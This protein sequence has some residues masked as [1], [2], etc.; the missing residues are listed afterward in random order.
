MGLMI[1][2]ATMAALG[3]VG[4]DSAPDRMPDPP[5]V[6]EPEPEQPASEAPPTAA[7]N[8]PAEPPIEEPGPVDEPEPERPPLRAP[9]QH[10][11]V[12]APCDDARP[13]SEW[14][15][16]DEEDG[17]TA[18]ADCQEGVNGR[19]RRFRFGW[20]CTY[21]RCGASADCDNV[22]LC[23]GRGASGGSELFNADGNVCVGGN[24]RS[25]ADC[26]PDGYCSPSFAGCGPYNGI[27]GFYCRTPDD[28]CVDDSDCTGEDDAFPT[29]GYCAFSPGAN[30]WR[31]EYDVCVGK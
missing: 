25:D 14:T 31:C 5:P 24:C 16:G 20:G 12:D 6:D 21:D 29:A 7:P 27:A 19:C 30:H 8:E 3:L 9:C 18:D 15:E 28:T 22:C 2:L 26:G 17:C 10:R 11:P 13:E 1:R 23:G 4:C